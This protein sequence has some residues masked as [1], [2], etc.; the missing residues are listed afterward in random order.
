MP[1]FYKEHANEAGTV[2]ACLLEVKLEE[3]NN[4]WR[5]LAV[6]SLSKENDAK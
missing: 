5:G 3:L 6:F 2:P 4:F 1:G